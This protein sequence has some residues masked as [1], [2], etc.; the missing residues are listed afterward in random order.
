MATRAVKGE[1]FK[2]FDAIRIDALQAERYTFP[3]YCQL[4][5]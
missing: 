1:F 5:T 4:N 2:A 3:I